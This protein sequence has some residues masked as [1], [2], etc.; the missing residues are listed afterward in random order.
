MRHLNPLNKN[1]GRITKVDK[2]KA[3]NLYYKDI[4]FPASKK[5]HKKIEQKNNIC[6]SVFCY[7]ND[8]VYPVHVSKQKFED[9]MD[10]LLINNENKSHYI[11]IK[12][13]NIFMF[14]KTKHR[15]KKHFCR[16]C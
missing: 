3:N 16:Y 6:I 9:F 13:F 14:N 2:T 11:Y 10:L 8:L 5:D 7:E 4:K 15:T 12:D 1:P